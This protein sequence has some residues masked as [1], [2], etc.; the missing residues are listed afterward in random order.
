VLVYAVATDYGEPGALG[1]GRR[2]GGDGGRGYDGNADEGWNDGEAY[3]EIVVP[4]PSHGVY[5]PLFA[6]V[7]LEVRI[8]PAGEP[9]LA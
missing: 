1:A 4:G 3:E 8:A 7:Y 5:I 2:R 9:Y 6:I